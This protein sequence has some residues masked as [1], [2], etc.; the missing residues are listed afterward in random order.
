MMKIRQKIGP[1][2][3]FAKGN[4]MKDIAKQ[5]SSSQIFANFDFKSVLIGKNY[6]WKISDMDL[7]LNRSFKFV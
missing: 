3:T 5:M 4:S 2:A 6:E 1:V 7:V